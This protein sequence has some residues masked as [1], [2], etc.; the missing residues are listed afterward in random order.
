MT[1]KKLCIYKTF[2]TD[3]RLHNIHQYMYM[4]NDVMS[5]YL[6]LLRMFI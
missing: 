3:L 6:F 1:I 2:I 5:N 4:L